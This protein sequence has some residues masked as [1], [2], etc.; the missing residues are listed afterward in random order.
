MSLSTNFVQEPAS[1]EVE[2]PPPA[3]ELSDDDKDKT[4]N[5]RG[6]D[7]VKGELVDFCKGYRMT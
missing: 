2:E 7:R 1:S 3:K 5:K 6:L 4:C